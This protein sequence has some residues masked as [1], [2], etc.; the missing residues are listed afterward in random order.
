ME[1][2]VAE[3]NKSRCQQVVS[4][5]AL[6]PSHCSFSSLFPF[7]PAAAYLLPFTRDLLSISCGQRRVLA[8]EG[9][10]SEFRMYPTNESPQTKVAGEGEI[11]CSKDSEVTTY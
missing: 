1:Q 8:F 3:F 11:K 9:T 2:S 6:D 5:S 7:C 4:L 10:Q